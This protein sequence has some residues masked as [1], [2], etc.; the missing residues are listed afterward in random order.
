MNRRARRRSALTLAAVALSAA[1]WSLKPLERRAASVAFE[2]GVAAANRGDA[3]GAQEAFTVCIQ[4]RPDRTDCQAGLG[5]AARTLKAEMALAVEKTALRRAE[6]SAQDMAALGNPVE[7]EAASV[8][9]QPSEADQ[10]RAVKHWNEGI[11]LFQ[12]GEYANAKDEWKLCQDL[13]PGN[14]DCGVGLQRLARAYG[15]EP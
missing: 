4:S 15:S 8:R 13:D 3:D 12:K 14:S 6:I 9:G 11:K 2:R 10:R 7:P 1:V 5:L